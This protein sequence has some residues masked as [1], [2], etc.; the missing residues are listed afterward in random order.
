MIPYLLLL[1]LWKW[2]FNHHLNCLMLTFSWIYIPVLFPQ[3]RISYW[4]SLTDISSCKSDRIDLTWSN[5]GNMKDLCG[6]VKF[7]EVSLL[8]L[9]I[10]TIPH[11]SAHCERIF[12][13]VRKNRT[14]QRSCLG[15][16]S[17]EALLVIKSTVCWF[18]K[19]NTWSHQKV[20]LQIIN[21]MISVNKC[22]VE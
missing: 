8:M 12:S 7:K 17:L 14:E 16:D 5:I 4:N 20:I 18:I 21:T 19:Q 11:S 9:G 13:C 1:K 15:D 10:L 3:L 2:S 22:F 6:S